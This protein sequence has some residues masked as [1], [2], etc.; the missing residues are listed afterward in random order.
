MFQYIVIQGGEGSCKISQ[1]ITGGGGWDW[2]SL[3]PVGVQHAKGILG[4][5]FRESHPSQLHLS[6]TRPPESWMS[7]QST[8]RIPQF[9]ELEVKIFLWQPKHLKDMFS[10]EINS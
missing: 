7:K 8:P 2:W 1:F 3:F 4:P 9:V 10:G 6:A 5:S